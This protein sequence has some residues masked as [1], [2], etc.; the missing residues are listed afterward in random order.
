MDLNSFETFN[1]KEIELTI[2]EE[3][4]E[5]RIEESKMAALDRQGRFARTIMPIEKD[6]KLGGAIIGKK[7]VQSQYVERR[8]LKHDF[9]QTR[10]LKILDDLKK[11]EK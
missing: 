4:E 1:D 7:T 10:P 2:A 6:C 5:R 9:A 3:E 8:Q 11:M